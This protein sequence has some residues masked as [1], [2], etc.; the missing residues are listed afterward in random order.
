MKRL[1]LA[2]CALT[3]VCPLFADKN[4]RDKGDRGGRGDG[5]NRGGGGGGGGQGKGQGG[6]RGGGGGGSGKQ[7][8]RK[9]GNHGGAGNKNKNDGASRTPSL[10][11][12]NRHHGQGGGGGH[13]GGQGN[14]Q[15]WQNWIGGG[16]KKNPQNA[17]QIG[18]EVKK[19]NHG[20]Q[21]N[22][23]R[24][25]F[26][27]TI[28]KNKQRNQDYS[29]KARN[30]FNRR[31]PNNK[32]W[33]N[34]GFNNRY[35]YKPKWGNRNRNWWRRNNW[36]YLSGWLPYGWS[37]PVYYDSGTTYQITNYIQSDDRQ[38]IAPPPEQ[39]QDEWM[40]L[41]VFAA[42][43]DAAQAA[44]SNLYVQLAVNKQGEIAGTYYNATTDTLQP[45]VGVIDGESQ[46]A[47][48]K[49]SEK[50]DSPLMVTSVYNLTQDVANITVYF[51]NGSQ[52]D[53]VLVSL[54]DE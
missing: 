28:G 48:W 12:E 34:D 35:N 31:H 36:G 38:V 10:S 18:Q 7:I 33:F 40:P 14:K 11:R 52:Q 23:N 19:Q 15:N 30:Q 42:G 1:I 17:G 21:K 53:W 6:N 46:Q 51:Q 5:G 49:L 50:P 8:D 41:G 32:N 26:K 39:A 16:G 54:E 45:L 4:D 3:L 37:D 24:Q 43:K 29:H 47:A 2:L 22:G 44:Y 13:G 20:W 25:D 9:G 27:N